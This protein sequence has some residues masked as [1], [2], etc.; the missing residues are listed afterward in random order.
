MP[1]QSYE[2]MVKDGILGCGTNL[3][4]IYFISFE[5]FI[6]MMIMNLFTAVVIEGFNISVR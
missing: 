6:S 4:Y 5:V 2:Q 3:S 1:N